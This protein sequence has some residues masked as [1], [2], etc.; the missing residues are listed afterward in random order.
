MAITFPYDL[1]D[2][3]PGWS[4]EFDLFYRQEQS[5]SASG[6]TFVKDF[7]SP[8]WRAVYQSRSLRINELDEWRARLNALDN[9]LHTFLGRSTSRCYP[10]NDPKGSIIG[11]TTITLS[12]ILPSRKEIVLAG[13]PVGYTLVAGDQIQIGTRNLHRVVAATAPSPGAATSQ[14]EVRPHIWPE[15][16]ASDEVKLIKPVCRM[17]IIPGSI[18]T[19]SDFST[20][21][22]SV[23]FQSIEA[24]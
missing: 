14:I 9:G 23:S 10:I 4:T 18:S 22:G 17:V 19:V 20:G 2:N 11:T 24:R 12:S 1:L 6:R 16:M 7:G 15:T 5:R 13:L 3:F 8:L 21:R